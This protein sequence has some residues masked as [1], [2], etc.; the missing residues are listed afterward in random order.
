[1]FDELLPT[2]IVLCTQ[3]TLTVCS[4]P[5][6]LSCGRLLLL[7]L[8]FF[9]YLSREGDRMK[10]DLNFATHEARRCADYLSQAQHHLSRAR[11]VDDEERLLREKQEREREAIRQKHVDEEVREED[12]EGNG[13]RCVQY[14]HMHA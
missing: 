8:R 6:S 2:Y 11:R 1:M 10:F 13:E 3:Y 7:L 14:L 9:V 4:T 5:F 12:R